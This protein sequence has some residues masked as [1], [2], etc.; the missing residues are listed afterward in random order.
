VAAIQIVDSSC[1]YQREPKNPLSK[2]D[3]VTQDFERN[4][5]L[6]ASKLLVIHVV[7]IVSVD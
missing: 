7:D 5:G 2:E 4:Y 6:G 3:R 1:S